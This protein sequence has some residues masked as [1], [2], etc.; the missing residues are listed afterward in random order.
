M[1]DVLRAETSFVDRI[2][3]KGVFIMSWAIMKA[4]SSA[5]NL[6]AHIGS[7]GSVSPNS[8][9]GSITIGAD[10]VSA[11]YELFRMVIKRRGMDRQ[12]KLKP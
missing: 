2:A 12:E 5:D 3:K 9:R 11:V 6:R 10:D 8:D 4:A 7:G 1:V